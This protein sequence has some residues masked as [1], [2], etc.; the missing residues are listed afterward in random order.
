MNNIKRKIKKLVRDPKLFFKDMYQKRV[1]H[2][3]QKRIIKH[4]TNNQYTIVSAVYNVAS[5]LDEYFI[6]ITKQTL[7]FKN[8][9]HII[10]VD[11]GSTDN[12]AEIIEK[13]QKKYPQNIH[14][15]YKEN[16]GQASARNLG[17][18]NVKTDWVTFIDPDD[19]I[20]ADYFHKIN[21]FL[22]KHDHISMIG[23]PLILY[24]EDQNVYKDT[25]PLKYRFAKGNVI[26]PLSNLKD[27]L[28]LS[29]STAI[30]KTGYIKDQGI[31]FDEEMKPS[32]EDAKF[33]T[34]Y[35]LKTDQKTKA[36][37]ISD[38]SYFY[39]K[40]SDGSSTLD[41]AW[42]NPLLFSR[43]IEKGCIEILKTAQRKFGVVPEHI[44]RIALYHIIWYFGR[45]VN[46]PASLSHLS[47]EQKENFVELLHQMFTY[48][49]E[50]TIE[51]FNLAGTWF[52]QK[53]A[54]LGLFKGKK[55]SQQIAYVED[56]DLKKNQVLIKYFSNFPPLERWIINNKEVYPS[57]QKEM[58][59]DFL[60]RLYTKEYRTWVQCP[61][62]G[63]LELF[64]HNQKVKLAFLGKQ[65]EKLSIST[66]KQHYSKIS[67]VKDDV[68]ILMDRDNQADDNAEHLYRY[69]SQNHPQHEIYFALNKSSSDWKRLEKEGF[70]L[71]EFGS[72]HFEAKLRDCSKIISSHIDGYIT[73]YFKD[74]SLL[75]KDYVFLQHGITKDDLSAWLNTKKVSLFVTATHDEYHSIA[76][77]NTSYKFGKK[78]V[79][80][81]G[82]PRYDKLLSG[83]K[84]NNQQILIMPT[85]RNSI[86]G[87]YI[88]GTERTRNS[89][90]MQSNYAQHW[91]SFMN[92]D[93]L[94]QLNKKGYDII[95][96]P[97][98]SIQEYMDEFTMPNFVKVYSYT[99]GNIQSL[100]QNTSILITDYSSVAFDVAYLNK[101]ILYYQFDYDEVFSGNHTYRKGYFDYERDGFGSVSYTEQ[102]LLEQ[103]DKLVENGGKL[104]DCYKERIHNTFAFR[105]NNNCKRVYQ[106]IINLD[107]REATTD[108]IL[109]TQ[110]MILQAENYKVWD[111][112]GERILHLLQSKKLND[113][114]YNEYEQKYLSALFNDKDFTSLLNYLTLNKVKNITY[115]QAKVDLQI[116]DAK[117][118][119]KYFTDNRVGSQED[120]LIATLAAALSKDIESVEML[121]RN[122]SPELPIEYSPLLLLAEK[123]S[124]QEYFV[125]ISLIENLLEQLS[126]EDKDIFK[127][128]LLASYICM[129]LNNLQQAHKYLVSYES[130]SK[131]DPS[132]RIAIARLAKLRHDDE[133]LFTQMNRAF[134][135]NLLLIPED[136]VPN[137]LRVLEQQKN[138]IAEETLLTQFREK[139]PQS[140]EIA[141]YKAEKLYR[142]N[143]WQA[144]ASL[145][146][147]YIYNSERAM[148]LYA[149]ALCR[150]GQSENVQNVL[151]M[152]PKQD[153]FKY[154]KLV[155][156]VAELK[157]DKLLLKYSIKK[158]LETL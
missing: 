144:L 63:N 124:Q 70:N 24:F 92:H 18:E 115:W 71:L 108:D 49:D 46:N 38:I 6:S 51:R 158:Q 102:E 87:S 17:L 112:A 91:H 81:T 85:W 73:H 55:P 146:I 134:E 61:E 22:D 154:W 75:D 23:C 84:T 3:K 39:R 117:Q 52:F 116:G 36:G 47:Q 140:Q 151:N 37:F 101:A 132:C 42:K 89:A 105:D 68:W 147:E 107:N 156:E 41:G 125:A 40:R 8:N 7:S 122:L 83:N 53:V 21:L 127:L 48:I 66:I 96:A 13:W 90:F 28:Q 93:V 32:F 56:F 1:I 19:F 149:L 35:I 148:Y 157:K 104:L 133:K 29:A 12:S 77:N 82:F 43:V 113:K 78:E 79:Q 126:S 136:L 120:K 130:H 76:D 15:I 118:A 139:Y 131:N 67:T 150:L 58:L 65:S 94:E 103:L 10:L 34:D 2:L 62:N 141:L 44:Q 121:S 129:R 14:Y 106:S 31:L 99:T 137:Y 98:P 16:G 119:I 30:F 69:I 80:L 86:V 153:S 111:L 27:H 74:N 123:I 128:E 4:K 26:L 5:Y 72:K 97:H 60:G 95:F 57:Y 109:I 110:K 138:I 100:F 20:S 142:S 11:D 25:H 88:K 54:L 45:I 135:D 50:K 114:E 9:I 143:E 64:L 59:Y 145:L 33:V 155:A 152:I